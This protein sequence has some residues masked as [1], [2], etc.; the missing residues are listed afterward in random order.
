M[1]PAERR[2]DVL[3]SVCLTDGQPGPENV[4]QLRSLTDE[5]NKHFRYWEML[6]GVDSESFGRHDQLLRDTPNLRLLKLRPGTSFYRKRVA[7]AAEAIGDVVVLAAIDELPLLDIIDIIAQSEAN[8]AI[9]IGQRP[10]SSL[11]NPALEVLGRSAGFRVS[12][13]YMQTAAYPRA[14]LDKLLAHPDRQLA[15]RFPPADDSFPV[16]WQ[17]VRAIGRPPRAPSQTG[18]RVKLLHR[19]LISC[20]PRV[21]TLV[22]VGS[23]LVTAATVLFAFYSIIVWLTFAYV[24]PGWLT[25]SLML[26]MTGA[27]LGCAI[28]GLSIGLQQLT[29]AVTRD[30]FD[31][32]V[33]EASSLDL[34]GQVF[35]ELN[36]EVHT[37]RPQVEATPL[38]EG[39]P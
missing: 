12:A 3:V 34:F 24:Q 31:D 15:L 5:L 16:R 25:T 19:L 4:M 39:G 1:P 27:F 23:L 26:S 37:S 38:A 6:V 18:R 13:R 21:L 36:V 11:L 22:A 8:D 7:I 35:H 14:L 28:F 10:G 29:E 2:D 33:D 20:A 17:D 9:I 32:V 30:S